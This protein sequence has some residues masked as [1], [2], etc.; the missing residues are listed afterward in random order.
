MPEQVNEE[1]TDKLIDV[2]E[3]DEKAT[4][5]DLDKKAEGG[6]VNETTQDSDKPADTPAESDN[7]PDVQA[8]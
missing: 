6:E 2:G 4:E 8:S 3:G 5:I 7:Q 1:K